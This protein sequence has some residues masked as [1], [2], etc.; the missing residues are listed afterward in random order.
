MPKLTAI[1]DTY[2]KQSPEPSTALDNIHK[3]F[4]KAG[5]EMVFSYK[6]LK[7][8]SYV[9]VTFANK[10]N[11]FFNWLVFNQH[12]TFSDDLITAKQ[13]YQ[14]CANAEFEVVQEYTPIINYY[15]NKYQFNKL[16][17]AHFLAQVL[18]ESGEFQYTEEIADGSE[19]EDRS[20]LGNVDAGDGS[21][22]KGRGLIQVTGHSNY[23]E[24]S[25]ATGVDYVSN[26]KKLAQSPD[27]VLSAFWFW[28]SRNLSKYADEDNF[29]AITLTVNGGYNGYD[30]RLNYLK[31]AKLVLGI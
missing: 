7:D 24:I 12:V 17:L 2:L 14:T 19:Y 3:I 22:Y 16:R 10:T 30:S 29:D 15:A 23:F 11:G 13:L 26:P 8:S 31:Q 6:T 18:H 20:D 4:V 27:C 25:K 21:K 5:T 9:T 1:R 28:N